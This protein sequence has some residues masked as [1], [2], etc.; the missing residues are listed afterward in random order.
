MAAMD[1]ASSDLIQYF[2]E[3][4]VPNYVDSAVPKL[5]ICTDDLICQLKPENCQ[6]ICRVNKNMRTHCQRKHGWK[7]QTQR[8][9]SS[10]SRHIRQQRSDAPEPWKIVVCQRFFVQE[11]ESQY[12]EVRGETEVADVDERDQTSAWG[13]VRKEMNKV[14]NTI[15]E[16]KQ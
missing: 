16:K 9:R 3:F 5:K 12:V 15:K 2:M 4:E 10:K 1:E 11:H 8:E 6:Y 7:Q 14:I 13:L